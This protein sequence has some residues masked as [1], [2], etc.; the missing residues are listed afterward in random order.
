MSI[1]TRRLNLKNQFTKKIFEDFTENTIAEE[2]AKEIEQN[3]KGYF[4][5]LLSWLEVNKDDT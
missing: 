5:I 4:E 1:I 2:T 3:L